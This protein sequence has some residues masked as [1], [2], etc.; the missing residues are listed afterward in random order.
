MSLRRANNLI[1]LMAMGIWI[2]SEYIKMNAF[3]KF[4]WRKE[5]V[6]KKCLPMAFF[7][8]LLIIWHG[9]WALVLGFSA[10]DYK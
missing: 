4:Q 6:F 2:I 10:T 8:P 9:P 5:N 1:L 3:S 7:F